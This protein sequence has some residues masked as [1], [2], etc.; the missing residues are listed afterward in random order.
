MLPP[1]GKEVGTTVDPTKGESSSSY[2]QPARKEGGGRRDGGATSQM[3]SESP[4]LPSHEGGAKPTVV[5]EGPANRIRAQQAAPFQL[6]S[7][8][9]L[10][11]GRR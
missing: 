1:L 5:A 2:Q 6:G 4:Q 11:A 10:Q 3:C 8:P 7:Y 9:S